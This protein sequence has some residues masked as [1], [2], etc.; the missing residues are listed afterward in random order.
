MG[1]F[2]KV[3]KNLIKIM[4]NKTLYMQSKQNLEKALK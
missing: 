1:V 2:V 4:Q 3:T